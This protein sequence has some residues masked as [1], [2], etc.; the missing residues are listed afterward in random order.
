MKHQIRICKIVE[1][2]ESVGHMSITNKIADK[3]VDKIMNETH[4]EYDDTIKSKREHKKLSDIFDT[5]TMYIF[6][7]S[8][9]ITITALLISLATSLIHTILPLVNDWI[10]NIVYTVG[11]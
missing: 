2:A 5:P 4:R 3:M 9:V 1:R 10:C 7:F 8:I 11:E 6:K